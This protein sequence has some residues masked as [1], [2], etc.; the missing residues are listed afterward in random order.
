MTPKPGLY[1]GMS[2]S[3]YKSIPYMNPS[4]LKHGLR[5]MLRLKRALDDAEEVQPS[6][7]TVLVGSI[8]HALVSGEAEELYA[9]LPEFELDDANKT[10]GRE[11][12]RP[13][14]MEKADGTPSAAAA[15]WV[16]K[17]KEVNA[18]PSSA[19]ITVG[20]EKTNSKTTKFY[21]ESVKRFA[22]QHPGKETITKAAYRVACKCHDS[23]RGNK[24]AKTLIDSSHHE[25][26]AI[27]EIEGV[28]CKTRIDGVG[29]DSNF[30]IL[31]DLKTTGD[32]APSAFWRV[33]NRLHYGFQFE[34][35]RQLVRAAGENGFEVQQYK[36]IAAETQDDYDVGVLDVPLA[37]L[38]QWTSRV[39]KT[40]ERYRLAKSYGDWPGLYPDD[41]DH[42]LWMPNWA[43]EETIELTGEFDG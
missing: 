17:C 21:Q 35:H 1:K 9:I 42:T 30:G 3:D 18:N 15:K 10:A 28:M 19:S 13:A 7:D 14:K 4:T 32:I 34:F 25:V 8:V 33:F 6:K 41:V 40:C 23:I 22:E 29:I 20:Q 36:T 12:K 37:N 31:W 2:W 39:E 5:S 26:V 24:K 16:A 27:G 43:M 11:I 38:E